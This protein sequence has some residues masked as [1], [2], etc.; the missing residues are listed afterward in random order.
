MER[1]QFTFYDSFLRAVSRIKK[2]QDRAKAYDAICFYALHGIEPDMDSLPDAAAIAFEIAK[3][4]LDASNKKAKSG[5]LGGS[6]TKQTASKTEK[7]VKQDEEQEKEQM[8][9][10]PNP[11][12]GG[13]T[14]KRFHPPSVEEVSAFCQEKGY[15]VDPEHFVAYYAARGWVYGKGVP[16]KDWKSAVRTWVK[17]QPGE[18]QTTPPP[19]PKKRYKTTVVDGE[20]VDVEI[21]EEE[22][23]QLSDDER[24]G[25]SLKI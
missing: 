20:L 11:L 17:N 8:L 25:Y 15:T 23:A 22:Y 2:L 1:T 14:S 13:K 3:P 24:Y 19:P 7:V 12:E 16:M 6:K 4:V 18:A 5:K 21:T 9:L 10:P